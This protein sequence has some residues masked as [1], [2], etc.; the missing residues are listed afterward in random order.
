MF[1][2]RVQGVRVGQEFLMRNSDALIHNVRS[3]AFRNR[4][5][6]IAQPAGTPDRKKVFTKPERALKIGC[7]I[8][9]WMTAYV[10][11][12]EHPYFAVTNEQGEFKIK[13]LPAGEYTL[14]AWHEQ[15]GKQEATF[16]VGPTDTAEVAF[17]F[18]EQA[19]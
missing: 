8:H 12:M 3:Y 10:F 6:N 2:P 17:T 1:R 15:F 5:F 4:A 19:K 14:E 11:V 9:G 13:G 7:D 18:K 16:N